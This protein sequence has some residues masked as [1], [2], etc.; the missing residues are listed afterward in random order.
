MNP[1]DTSIL[2][3]QNNWKTSLNVNAAF[4]LAHVS[5]WGKKCS[6]VRVRIHACALC[7]RMHACACV[8]VRSACACAYM[9]VRVCLHVCVHM[10]ACSCAGACV[11]AWSG[12]CVSECMH[13]CSHALVCIV[14]MHVRILAQMRM[15]ICVCAFMSDY[16]C[17]C[18]CVCTDMCMSWK[19]ACE[20]VDIYARANKSSACCLIETTPAD[21]RGPT[22]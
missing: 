21:S 13:V 3:A 1:S 4:T 12:P 16:T 11:R 7:G 22:L 18:I 19:C 17:I 15:R 8:H 20:Y 9:H 10:H 5:H 2:I 14:C 6:R